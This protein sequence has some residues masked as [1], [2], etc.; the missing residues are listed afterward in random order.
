MRLSCRHL[1]H[2]GT[3]PL[4]RQKPCQWLIHRTATACQFWKLEHE[5]R[6]FGGGLMTLLLFSDQAQST[7]VVI[8]V[9]AVEFFHLIQGQHT[10]SFGDALLSCARSEANVSMDSADVLS[11]RDSS[12]DDW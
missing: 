4:R 6:A 8:C 1:R 12:P 10:C 7:Q 5:T 2:D 9:S 11:G 3:F